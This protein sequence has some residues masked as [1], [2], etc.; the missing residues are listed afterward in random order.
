MNVLITGATDGL[1]RAL[2]HALARQGVRLLL[3]G[4]DP[5]RLRET[6]D[7]I[8]A[9][10]AGVQVS[11]HRADFASLGDVHAL[12]VEVRDR[13]PRLDVLVNNA[14]VGA[15]IPGAEGRPVSD[16]GI[17][18][19]FAVNYLAHYH[20]TRTLLPLLARSRPSRV[21]NISSV[22]QAAFEIDFSDL[23]LHRGFDA[24][25]AY[26]QSK[27][28]QVMFTIDLAA[29]LTGRGVTVDALHPATFMPT[30][31]VTHPR[32]GLDEGVQA[33]LQLINSPL[34]GPGGRYFE[35]GAARDPN[36]Q[37]LE[38]ASRDRLRAES[39]RLVRRVLGQ[40]VSSG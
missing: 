21:V 6:A 10:V 1:G 18:L 5:R 33:V 4:R 2:A 20:L 31:M 19:R 16:D 30:K 40:A 14:G 24:G 3:H 8:R 15:V 7:E 32:S 22:A 35:H 26:C 12:A 28:A 34:E 36:P 27:L 9:A 29:E 23:Q 17:E 38:P 37:A 25:R 11:T 13:E 39:R